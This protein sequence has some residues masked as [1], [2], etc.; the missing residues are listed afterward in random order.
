M[1]QRVLTGRALEGDNFCIVD[2]VKSP[3]NFGTYPAKLYFF[4]NN[5]KQRCG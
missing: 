1:V 5:F 2:I 3:T 4:I